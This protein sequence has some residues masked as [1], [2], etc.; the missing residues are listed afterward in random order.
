MVALGEMLNVSLVVVGDIN[1]VMEQY[2][3]DVR[4]VNVQ[5]GTIVAKDGT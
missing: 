4:V 5:T 2:N 3:V 1:V